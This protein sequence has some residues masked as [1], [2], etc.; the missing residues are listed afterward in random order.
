MSKCVQW[1]YGDDG[2]STYRNEASLTHYV[3][4]LP[5]YR[6][7]SIDLIILVS[8]WG[9]HWHLM[10]KIHLLLD[11]IGNSQMTEQ[12]YIT[13]VFFCVIYVFSIT[14]NTS[15]MIVLLTYVCKLV[16]CEVRHVLTY[17]LENHF[18]C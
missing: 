4:V 8:I 2:R 16:S 9:Q 18:Y 10:G 6:N 1:G 13:S 17:M 5:S 3:P 14:E 15:S 11:W 12:K 7:Q